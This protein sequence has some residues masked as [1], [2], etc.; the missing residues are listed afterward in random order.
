MK[1]ALALLLVGLVFVPGAAFAAKSTSYTYSECFVN[2]SDVY[3]SI[4]HNTSTNF[5]L[6][7]A[8]AIIGLGLFYK[9]SRTSKYDFFTT[10]CKTCGYATNGLKCPMCQAKKQRAN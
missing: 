10:K 6:L 9:I 8:S 7:G 5:L 4:D 1:I 2:C 3:A